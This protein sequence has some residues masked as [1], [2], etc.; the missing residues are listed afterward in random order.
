MIALSDIKVEGSIYELSLVKLT[1]LAITDIYGYLDNQFDEP[2]WNV[3]KIMFADGSSVRMNGE[4]DIAYI[5]NGRTMPPH[6][7]TEILIQL[8]GEQ[9]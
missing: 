6:M 1:G 3:T 5:E 2:V 9:S 8:Y 7:D 4:H